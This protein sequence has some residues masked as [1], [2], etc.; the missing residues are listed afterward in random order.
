MEA[1]NILIVGGRLQG[2]EIAYLACEAGYRT[3]LVDRNAEVPARGIATSFVQADARYELGMLPLV[4]HADVII[5]AV[6]DAQVLERLV[7]YGRATGTPVICDLNAYAISSSKTR[8]N[9]LFDRLSLRIPGP[10]PW[11]GFPAIVKPDGL[12]GSRGV[13]R[14]NTSGELAVAMKGGGAV[15][16]R[17]VEGRSF[18]MEVIGNGKSALLMPITEVVTGD[19][20]D[21][22]RIEAPAR[23]TPDERTQFTRIAHR[24]ADALHIDGIFDI[25]VISSNGLLYV[26][27]ID[28]RFPSQTPIAIYHATGINM[29]DA[30]VRLK[31]GCLEMPLRNRV[32]ACLYQQVEISRGGV[33]LAGE[34]AMASC[35]PLRIRH[36][37][38]GADVMMTDDVLHDGCRRAIVINVAPTYEKAHERFANCAAAMGAKNHGIFDERNSHVAADCVR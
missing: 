7:A 20:F 15:V 35:G 34:H 25:E 21:C 26:L 32:R 3:L 4:R 31:L 10:Y 24:L 18:S 1:R 9:E 8:S 22:V 2:T 28:A 30:L 14:V 5:P 12:S 33:A 16:Q 27:E 19:D 37:A 6:E 11:C 23:T 29:V 17:F 36:G 13:H 38:Y